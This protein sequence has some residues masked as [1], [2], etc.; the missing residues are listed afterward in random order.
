MAL[1]LTH[2]LTPTC[3][4]LLALPLPPSSSPRLDRSYRTRLHH[5]HQLHQRLQL[6]LA[7]PKQLKHWLN[8][9]LQMI[10][11]VVTQPSKE[12]L[13][14]NASAKQAVQKNSRYEPSMQSFTCLSL[15]F[16]GCVMVDVLRSTSTIR[17]RYSTCS[18]IG[19][20]LPSP[21]TPPFRHLGYFR[22]MFAETVRKP[23]WT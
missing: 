23:L 19:R 1:L 9:R 16:S 18:I 14:L 20:A 15:Y 13:W 10:K 17:S 8:N 2:P 21:P 7:Q 12:S 5:H 22:P 6:R 4:D 11:S 3:S